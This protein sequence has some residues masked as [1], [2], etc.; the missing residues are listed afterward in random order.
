MARLVLLADSQPGILET[1]PV[2]SAGVQLKEATLATHYV[3]SH[4]LPELE[5]E[6]QHLGTRASSRKAV[7]KLLAKFEVGSSCCGVCAVPGTA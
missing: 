5:S 6:L 1:H 2:V 4:L 7:H 3:P